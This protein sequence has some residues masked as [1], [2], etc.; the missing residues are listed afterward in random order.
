[1][2]TLRI[3][4]IV[5]LGILL[6]VGSSYAERTRKKEKNKT[7]RETSERDDRGRGEDRDRPEKPDRREKRDKKEKRDNLQQ[8][9]E[10]RGNQS[11]REESSPARDRGRQA[12]TTSLPNTRTEENRTRDPLSDEI[13]ARKEKPLR[14][15]RSL[16]ER[17]RA[18]RRTSESRRLVDNLGDTL[19]KLR[20]R[21]SYNPVDD[22]EQGNAGRVLMRDPYGFD[23]ERSR[24]EIGNQGRPIREDD[25]SKTKKDHPSKDKEEP[26]GEPLPSGDEPLEDPALPPSSALPPLNLEGITSIESNNHY[27]YL[28]KTLK[29]R[30]KL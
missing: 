13:R 30:H 28:F 8:P 20:A 2:K 21:W 25:K 23:K 7:R 6:T 1:M 12:E 9:V 15:S 5:T 29:N 16:Q 11:P 27:E 24:E 3:L 17:E 26:V 18:D 10:D 22:R 4:F 14:N 19:A